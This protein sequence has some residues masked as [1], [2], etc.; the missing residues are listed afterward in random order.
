MGRYLQ[1][2]GNKCKLVQLD[3]HKSTKFYPNDEISAHRDLLCG[4]SWGLFPRLLHQ[5]SGEATDIPQYYTH[6]F[7]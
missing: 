7:V 2:A 1:T 4:V 3:Q 5:N 6:V